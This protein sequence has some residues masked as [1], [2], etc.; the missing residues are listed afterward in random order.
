MLPSA[1]GSAN[2]VLKTDGSGN[3]AWVSVLGAVAPST[4]GNVMTSDGSNWVSAGL[5]I[6][7]T[8]ATGVLRVGTGLTVTVSGVVSADWGAAAGKVTEGNDKRLAPA[9]SV[10]DAFKVVRQNALGDGY[11]VITAAGLMS[12]ANVYVQGGNAFGA[13][14]TIGTSDANQFRLLA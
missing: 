6:G 14:A 1:D 11:E 3:L 12:S 4:A 2:Q 8:A 5:P 10:T 9:P 13:A 7:T